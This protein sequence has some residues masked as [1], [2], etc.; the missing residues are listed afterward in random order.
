MLP[1][2]DQINAADALLVG[3]ADQSKVLAR[4]DRAEALF[5]SDPHKIMAVGFNAGPISWNSF[6]L[7][8][9]ARAS[10][11][12]I[13]AGVGDL[14]RATRMVEAMEEPVEGW[15]S[16][17]LEDLPLHVRDEILA[18]ATAT[19]SEDEARYV[20]SEFALRAVQPDQDRAEATWALDL[21]RTIA[22]RAVEGSHGSTVPVAVALVANRAGD[23]NLETAA[24]MS[25]ARRA[26]ADRDA[27]G[28][29]SAGHLLAENA[30]SE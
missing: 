20:V 14:E 30:R 29:I 5:P 13:A 12:D 11:A 28:L 6:G 10:I 1:V 23:E 27:S 21:A 9:S 19:L 18:A 2:F 26:L 15:T 24:V 16:L 25:F 4:L 3:G 22:D 7:S 8:D 17:A